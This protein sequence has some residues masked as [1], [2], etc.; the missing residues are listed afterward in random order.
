MP[1][2]SLFRFQRPVAVLSAQATRHSDQSHQKSAA[3][4]QLE[5]TTIQANPQD[6]QTAVPISAGTKHLSRQAARLEHIFHNIPRAVI[7]T[8]RESCIYSMKRA[9]KALLGQLDND[10]VLS[11]WP[12]ALLL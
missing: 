5:G 11:G 7:I 10:L 4:Y 1:K 2:A 9:A 12:R 6:Q 8:D 3:L